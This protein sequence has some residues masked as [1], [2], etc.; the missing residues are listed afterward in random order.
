MKTV[1]VVASEPGELRG[2][3]RKCERVETLNWPVQFVR[4]AELNGQRL[5]LVAHG[6]GP[7]AVKALDVA[8]SREKA[9]AVVSTGFCG[10]LDATLKAGDVFVASRIANG[11]RS[12]E[13]SQPAAARSFRSGTLVSTDLVAGSVAEK[14]RLRAD[15]AS[16]V[17]MEAGALAGRAGQSGVPFYCVRAVMDPAGEGFVLDFNKLRDRDGRFSR[18]RILRAALA[19]P[20]ASLP[21]LIRLARQGRLAARA[22]GDFIADCRF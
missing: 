16:V 10:G 7:L 20:R 17:E 4:S 15:G 1:L 18:L 21:E 13:P 22:L 14:E 3:L 9:D 12:Y 6:P 8:L 2:I 5:I 19:R 11:S